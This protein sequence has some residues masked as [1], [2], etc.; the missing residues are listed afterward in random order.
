MQKSSRGVLRATIWLTAFTGCCAAAVAASA[1]LK[2]EAHIAGPTTGTVAKPRAAVTARPVSF[3]NDVV[4]I[5]TRYG[6]NQ[7]T[8][9]GAQYGKG[10]F[11][12]SL[13]GYDPDLDYAAIVK[14][15]RGRRVSLADPAGSLFLLKPS[16]SVPHGGGRRFERADA[17]SKVLLRWLAE[18]AH[19]PN[20]VDPTVAKIDVIPNERILT[21]PGEKLQVRVRATYSDGTTRDVTGW[22]R[23]NTLND[24]IASCTPAGQVT[25]VGRGQTAIMARYSGRATVS[26]IIVPFPVSTRKAV[27]RQAPAAER[28]IDALVARKQRQLGLV[29]SPVCDDA[30]FIRRVSFDLIGTPPT[31]D[32]IR[33]FTA[34]TRPDKRAALVD[35]LLGRPEYADYWTLKWG[36]LLRSNRQNLT[37]KGMWSFTNWIH[38]QMQSDRPAD[39]FVH[40]LLLG[41]GSTFTNG[42]ANYYRVAGS[43]EDLAETTSQVFLGVRLQ[44]AKCHH[45]PFEKWSQADYYQ[46]AAFFARVG[47]KNSSDFGLFGNET[48]VKIQDGGEVYL[49]KS[50]ALMRPSALGVVP[51]SVA[52]G[53]KPPDPDVGGDRRLALAD[54]LTRSDNRLFSRN[55]ANRYWGYL[56]GKGIVNPIDDQRVTNPPTNPELLD[57]LADELVASRFDLKHLLRI[58]CCS[59]TY[60]RSSDATPLNGKDELFFTHYTMKRLPAETLLDAIDYACGTHEKFSDLPAGTRAIQLPDPVPSDFLDTFGRPQRLIACECERYSEPNLSQTLRLMNGPILNNKVG[61]GNGRIA[62]LIGQSH[63]DAYILN[64]LYMATLGRQPQPRERNMVLGTLAFTPVRE[65]KS[66]FED[67]LLTLLNSKEF[68]LNH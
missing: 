1:P 56:F 14:Q 8:C 49:P 10:G 35:A 34:D 17:D 58:I 50:G 39:Q 7:G 29:P 21:A 2:P 41:Q 26:T 66:V 12:L 48:V 4:P 67:V 13:A 20:P 25:A 43:P 11:K 53:A 15:A 44:C 60:Q 68:L 28:S 57:Y 51:A 52:T 5:L 54:W 55:L 36:D 46:F 63:S 27:E 18:G 65:R 33:R 47:Q 3:D 19:G 22:T 62:K 45:H 23:L 30:S 42:P 37:P 38:T 9:H 24:A 40:E 61:D 59:K 31:P 64:D 6:C 16:L 32:E